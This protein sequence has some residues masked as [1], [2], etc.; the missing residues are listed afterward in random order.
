MH[1]VSSGRRFRCAAVVVGVSL[2]VGLTGCS[3]PTR[4]EAPT[5]V[6]AP[7]SRRPASTGPRTTTRPGTTTSSTSTSVQSVA[8]TVGPT[9]PQTSAQP[10]PTT[11]P[12]GPAVVV[13]Q[14]PTNRRVVALTFDAGSDAGYA[15]EVLDTLT[16][17]RVPASFGVTGV[18]AQANPSLVRR[19]AAAGQ[20]LDH[21]YDHRSF[22]GVSTA[23][24]PL[25]AAERR[26]ELIRG[27][28]AIRAAGVAATAPWFRPPYGDEDPSVRVDVA[29]AGYH[30]EVLWS[31]DSLGWKGLGADQIVSR[32]LDPTAARPGAIYL[33]HVGSQ[34]ADHAALRRVI[35]GLR[36]RGFSFAT[37]AG[38][39]AG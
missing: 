2:G 23:T 9:A 35:A 36:A 33:F 39:L 28:A 31:L 10:S 24:A 14:G 6:R 11:T 8:P 32:C 16:A 34:S 19:M 30:Y 20:I 13:R 7:T 4:S 1:P 26:S 5:S 18:W 37:V 38:L 22:T 27:D 29:A 12:A 3:H 15:G 25:S 17:E 21:T